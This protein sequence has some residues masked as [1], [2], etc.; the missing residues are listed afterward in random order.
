[1]PTASSAA[2]V[3]PSVRTKRPTGPVATARTTAV[4]AARRLPEYAAIAVDLL[5]AASTVRVVPGM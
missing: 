3:E 5:L 2:D 1:M 4:A